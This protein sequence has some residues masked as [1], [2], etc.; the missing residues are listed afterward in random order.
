MAG[1]CLWIDKPHER[2][3]NLSRRRAPYCEDKLKLGAQERFLEV[4][5]LIYITQT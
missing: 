1:F 4:E 2:Q 3:Q 5:S